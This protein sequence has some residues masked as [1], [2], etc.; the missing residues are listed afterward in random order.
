M[1]WA[2]RFARLLTV[3]GGKGTSSTASTAP[4]SLWITLPTQRSW[5][6]VEYFGSRKKSASNSASVSGK[7][8]MSRLTKADDDVLS[9][10]LSHHSH[11][12]RHFRFFGLLFRFPLQHD[13]RIVAEV[14][15][16][17]PLQFIAFK[18][19]P[20]TPLGRFHF[21]IAVPGELDGGLAV[22]FAKAV[23]DLALRRSRTGSHPSP[24]RRTRSSHGLPRQ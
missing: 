21:V 19:Q 15:V 6:L 24:W 12:E 5:R 14:D 22:P 1:A 11:M 13:P 7:E 16:N 20:A 3:G 17:H 9:F 4:S 23:V 10:S 8:R 2:N 18:D